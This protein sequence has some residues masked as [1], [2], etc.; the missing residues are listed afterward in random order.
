MYSC[1][2]LC[3]YVSGVPLSFLKSR[4][5]CNCSTLCGKA[6]KFHLCI[7]IPPPLQ[8]TRYA[9]QSSP[10]WK[11][12]A[13]QAL[14]KPGQ[15]SKSRNLPMASRGPVSLPPLCITHLAK[16]LGLVSASQTWPGYSSACRAGLCLVFRSLL[17]IF[18]VPVN[19]TSSQKPSFTF[20]Q[21]RLPW[22]CSPCPCPSW[23]K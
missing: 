18:C 5:P 17:C 14:V 3:M 13:S 16:T 1:K 9:Q 7:L 20:Q 10:P 2:C 8:P 6:R 21:V 11:S 22:L 23:F 19:V 12:L 4:K 15:A